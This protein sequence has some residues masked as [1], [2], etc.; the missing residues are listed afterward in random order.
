LG[1]MVLWRVHAVTPLLGDK[2]PLNAAKHRVAEQY[3][4]AVPVTEPASLLRG[5]LYCPAITENTRHTAAC[6]FGGHKKT[7]VK[8]GL[9]WP[10]SGLQIPSFAVF[11]ESG[12]IIKPRGE[13][14]NDDIIFME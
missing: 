3:R 4:F 14:V 9:L 2:P 13:A 1:G 10:L 11:D 8:S 5:C 7:T 6:V 12:A